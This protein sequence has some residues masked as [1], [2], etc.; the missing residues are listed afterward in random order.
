MSRMIVALLAAAALAACATGPSFDEAGVNRNVTP[1]LAATDATLGQGARVS[2]GGII[3]GSSNLKDATQIEVLGH[4]VGR[5]RRPD[6]AA[7]PIG[8]F[9][10]L[11][12]GYLETADYAPG[13]EITVVGFLRGT[14]QGQ[15]G[16]AAYTYPVVRPDDLYLWPKAGLRRGPDV[17]FGIG[18]GIFR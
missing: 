6:T 4:P 2:W 15:V 11:K 10:I 8:R 1:R 12:E 13:R 9:L 14:Q 18:V 17:H 5:N 3:L 16:G 7:N